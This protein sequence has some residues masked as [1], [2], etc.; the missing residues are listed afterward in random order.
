MSWS[1]KEVFAPVLT[2]FVQWILWSAA[3]DGIR[4]V[5]FLARDGYPMYLAAQGLCRRSFPAVECRYLKCSRY[6]LG[7]PWLFVA[8]ERGLDRICS[9]GVDVTPR[10]VLRRA[11]L[12]GAK[13]FRALE[14]LGMEREADLVLSPEKLREL[15]EKLAGCGFFWASVLS[16]AR[17]AYKNTIG[18]LRQEGFGDGVPKAVADSGWTGGM[19]QMLGELL[20]SAG[21]RERLTGYYFGLYSLPEGANSSDYS[22]YYFRPYGD[23]K[24]KARF[25]NCLFECVFTAPH[26]MTLGYREADGAFKPVLETG[27]GEPVPG[28][29]SQGAGSLELG[30]GK[31]S[32]ETG[33]REPGQKSQGA[34]K[35]EPGPRSERDAEIIRRINRCVQREAYRRAER[36]PASMADWRP[37][38]KEAKGNLRRLTR[39][40]TKPDAACARLFGGMAF[41]D[42]SRGKE[43]QV[44]APGLPDRLLRPGNFRSGSGTRSAWME[45]SIAKCGRHT[46]GRFFL[47]R[48]YRYALY[49][50]KAWQG[51][52]C[53][54]KG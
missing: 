15:K 29:R 18:Y 44:L 46:Q 41:S 2:D 10:M 37:G 25:S 12:E 17:G 43:G 53:L 31:R 21:I 39:L 4:R 16:G 3:R 27:N 23:I 30:P 52:A 50:R 22:A 24:R 48:A 26:G 51:K 33:S 36:L 14:A 47:Y 42:D 9:A 7:L 6:S 45:G 54:R 5:Y 35:R 32:Q 19:Q 28:K 1:A 49:A 11:G 13:A 8:G 40:M 34:G 38:K 20:Y